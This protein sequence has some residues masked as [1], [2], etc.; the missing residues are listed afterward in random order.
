M[1]YQCKLIDQSAQPV[2]S[3]RTQAAM[4]NLPKILGQS[5]GAIAQY[6]GQIGQFPAGEPFAAYYNMDMQNLDLEIGFPVAGKITGKDNIQ[7][8]EIPAGKAV[9]CLHVGPY[10]KIEKAYEAIDRWMKANHVEPSGVCYEFYLNDPQ[11][12]PPEA[13]ETRIMFPLKP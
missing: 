6:L 9:T 8:G 5:Y 2:A 4:E 1:S 12:T 11:Q 10:D 3:I 13:L 7:P